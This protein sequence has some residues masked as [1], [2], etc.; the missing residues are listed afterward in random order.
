MEE[1]AGGGGQAEEDAVSRG[2]RSAGVW[3]WELKSD[4]RK[5]ETLL[6]PVFGEVSLF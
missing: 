1:G 5:I 2:P 3:G 4:L 6:D